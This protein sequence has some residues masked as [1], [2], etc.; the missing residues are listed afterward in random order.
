MNFG[1]L[2]LVMY[3]IVAAFPAFA[4]R[5]SVGRLKHLDVRCVWVQEQLV[6]GTYALKKVPRSKNPADILTHAPSSQELAKFI[7]MRGLFPAE[8]AKG[9]IEMTEAVLRQQPSLTPKLAAIILAA[10][11]S[12]A[13]GEVLNQIKDEDVRTIVYTLEVII[14]IC[15]LFQIFF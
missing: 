7:P 14:F 8:C 3:T 10:S 11:A 5:T 12:G 2:P 4:H 13:R 1:R 15:G 6:R 9:A